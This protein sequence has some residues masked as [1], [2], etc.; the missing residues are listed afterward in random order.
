MKNTHALFSRKKDC[1]RKIKTTIFLISSLF[2]TA[3]TV[4]AQHPARTATGAAASHFKPSFEELASDRIILFEDSFEMY[5]DF[6]DS[7]GEWTLLD[8]DMTLTYLIQEA[9]YPGEGQSMAFIVF[10]PLTTEP[11]LDGPW[12]AAVGNKYAASFSSL[13]GEGG[14]ND[15]WLISPRIRLET[16]SEV[17]F[18]AR[19]VTDEYGL[20][21]FRVGISTTTPQPVNFEMITGDDAVLAPAEWTVF[22]FDISEYDSDSVYVA[23]QSI[24]DDRFVFMVDDF[25]VTGVEGPSVSIEK[26]IDRPVSVVLHQNYPNPFNPE[27]TIRFY[28]DAPRNVQVSVYELSG[29]KVEDVAS[30]NYP[31]GYHTVLFDGSGLASG[32]YIYRLQTDDFSQTRKLM[33]L[34]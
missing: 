26:E 18:L 27:T 6:S 8:L 30:G 16:E 15:N 32:V 13:P 3:N 22:R 2:L 5:E 34:K 31:Q 20:E 29:K 24:S 21:E 7:L 12:L 19:S 11:P 23:I 14:P 33:L 9:S 17:R 28:L 1:S 25:Q 10:N 4:F